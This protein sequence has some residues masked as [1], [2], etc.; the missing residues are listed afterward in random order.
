[1]TFETR[2][3]DACALELVRHPEDFDVI[4]VILPQ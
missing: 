2:N 3:V 1:V 4:L